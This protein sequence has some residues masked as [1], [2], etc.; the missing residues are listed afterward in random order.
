MK[1]EGFVPVGSNRKG[2]VSQGKDGTP[3]DRA[4]RIEMVRLYFQPAFCISL[5]HLL[6]D[7]PVIRGKT[8]V[9]KDLLYLFLFLCIHMKKT[10][11]V[12]CMN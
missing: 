10:S 4:R 6:N 1:R 5:I 8:V 9:G 12:I 7:C 3:H 2:K 11:V